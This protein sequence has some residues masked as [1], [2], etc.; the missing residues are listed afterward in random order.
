MESRILVLRLL[1]RSELD[2]GMAYVRQSGP[3]EATVEAGAP[4]ADLFMGG[5]NDNP[6]NWEGRLDEV[7]YFDRP[8]SAEEVATLSP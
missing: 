8:L 2:A 6:S 3:T 7:A 1:E 5:R 4:A